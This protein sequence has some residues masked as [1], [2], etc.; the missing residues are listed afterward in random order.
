M[1]HL[2]APPLR[3]P[4]GSASRRPG[5]VPGFKRASLEKIST[6]FG[7]GCTR[8]AGMP[9]R[10]VASD[11]FNVRLHPD[12]AEVTAPLQARAVTRG[13]DVYF[14]PGQYQP[15]TPEGE[16]L[17]AHELA[18]TLQ[19]R[20]SASAGGNTASFVSQPGDA[21]E[22]NA[23][24]LARGETTHAL[25][26]P[27]GAALRSPFASENAAAYKRRQKALQDAQAAIRYVEH[28]LA[29]GPCQRETLLPSGEFRIHGWSG[30]DFIETKATRTA[31]LSQLVA[32][33]KKIQQE[34]ESAVLP[35]GEPADQV[36]YSTDKG[37]PGMFVSG[38]EI[39]IIYFRHVA[40]LGL[41]ERTMFT[42]TLYIDSIV[43]RRQKPPPQPKTATPLPH[44]EKVATPEA[45]PSQAEDREPPRDFEDHTRCHIVVPDPENAPLV[46]HPLSTF[47]DNRGYIPE[48][49]SDR[50]G[51]F[52]KTATGGKIHLPHWQRP[53]EGC[54]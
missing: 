9:A 10:P 49:L 1:M 19:T 38:H 30:N 8:C 13:Q 35:V 41:G 22:R 29:K 48:V 5:P 44:A 51:Y 6:T 27:A 42:N 24:A 21:F 45:P 31:R 12:A 2:L 53:T 18:H 7:G 26:A 15:G 3:K 11:F 50:K 4:S 46:Y 20:H 54:L 36:R 25:S 16:A 37:I 34:L 28:C 14:H 47:G 32:D 39:D 52:Y 23:D 17:I 40:K 33:L 43:E